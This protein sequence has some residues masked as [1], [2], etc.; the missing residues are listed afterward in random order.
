[1]T[2][3]KV[4]FYRPRDIVGRIICWITRFPYSHVNVEIDTGWVFDQPI[5]GKSSWIPVGWFNRFRRWDECVSLETTRDVIEIADR[6]CGVN[7][8]RLRLKTI[9]DDNCVTAAVY[10]LRCFGV[11][12]PASVKT[13]EQLYRKLH[14]LIGTDPDPDRV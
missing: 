2:T 5:F 13:P 9:R 11:W 3:L 14:E 4:R 1:M 10:I 8:H 6:L 12:V 7:G